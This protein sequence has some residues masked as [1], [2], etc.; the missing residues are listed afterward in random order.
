MTKLTAFAIGIILVAGVI[1]TAKSDTI[2]FDDGTTYDLKP[3]E[4]VYVSSGRVW[5]FTKFHPLDL[6]VQALEPMSTQAADE[7]CLTFG[8]DSCVTSEPESS[9]SVGSEAILNLLFQQ[10]QRG[11]G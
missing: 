5:E 2:Y 8:G 3:G 4:S 6:R 9:D 7:E 1:S 11:E 10:S